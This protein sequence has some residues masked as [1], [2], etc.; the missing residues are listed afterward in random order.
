MLKSTKKNSQ[1]PLHGSMN[2]SENDSLNSGKELTQQTNVKHLD[3]TPFI[4]IR[5]NNKYW[6]AIGKWRISDT[7]ESETELIKAL[8]SPNWNMLI[9][10][11]HVVGMEAKEI[12][13]LLSEEELKSAKQ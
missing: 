4:M 9:A 2:V 13:N 10:V 6:A 5:S 12:G 3:G 11:M 1:E 7:Y 8:E